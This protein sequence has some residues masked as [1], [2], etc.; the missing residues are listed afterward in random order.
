MESF[1]V[2]KKKKQVVGI[3]RP[4]WI[5]IQYPHLRKLLFV[6]VLLLDF[7]TAT[8]DGSQIFLELFYYLSQFPKYI[9][10]PIVIRLCLD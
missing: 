1:K 4:V 3:G 5:F 10:Q 9:N 6:L 7:P 8:V 2:K